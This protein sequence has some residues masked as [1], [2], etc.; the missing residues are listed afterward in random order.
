MGEKNKKKKKGER[1]N[2]G[3]VLVREMAADWRA[4]PSFSSTRRS[5]NKFCTADAYLICSD[6]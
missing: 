6:Q 2:V 1:E 5:F 4:R 3:R